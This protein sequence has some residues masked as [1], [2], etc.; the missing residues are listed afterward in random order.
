MNH[1]GEL[2]V[3][4]HSLPLFQL[5]GKDSILQFMATDTK[6]YENR[7]GSV[8]DLEE[9]F[10]VSYDDMEQA[11]HDFLKEEKKDRTRS[12]SIVNT[13]SVFGGV[14]LVVA[15]MMMLQ[16][17]GLNFGPEISFSRH[18]ILPSIA[19]LLLLLG[20]SGIRK[21]KSEERSSDEALPEFKLRPDAGKDAFRKSSVDDRDDYA[22]SKKKMLRRSRTDKRFLGVCGGIANYFGFDPTVVRIIFGLSM[23]FYGTPVFLYFMLAIIMKKEP[24]P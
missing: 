24:R 2:Y 22:K 10:R 14:M 19:G 1:R 5:N 17:F 13:A 7:Q 3:R 11:Y 16:L 18:I 21:N 15:F 6:N 23:A 8:S 4:N 20:W 12:R 9:E